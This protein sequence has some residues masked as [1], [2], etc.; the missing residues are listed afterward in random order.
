MV[1]L[2]VA[3][4]IAEANALYAQLIAQSPLY[5]L[6]AGDIALADYLRS[7]PD[8]ADAG[9]IRAELQAAIE[10]RSADELLGMI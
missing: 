1:C 9:A 4:E 8:N 3:G 7:F 6:R 10:R 2:L 5:G